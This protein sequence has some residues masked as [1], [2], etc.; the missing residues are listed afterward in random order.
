MEISSSRGLCTGCCAAAPPTTTS[1]ASARASRNV[2]RTGRRRSGIMAKTAYSTIREMAMKTRAAMGLAGVLLTM[3][4]PIVSGARAQD[5]EKLAMARVRLTTDA[6]LTHGCGRIGSV[7]DDSVKDLRRKIVKMGGNTGLL[8]FGGPEGLS[9]APA[10]VL[11]RARPPARTPRTGP[12]RVPAPPPRPP[13]PP[14][15]T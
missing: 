15:P 12:A 14:H 13:P 10:E 2:S 6:G 7:H 9:T 3:S 1:T 11:R 4:A 5:L 8:S